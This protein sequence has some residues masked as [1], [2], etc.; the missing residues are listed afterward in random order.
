M[1][2]TPESVLQDNHIGVLA[3]VD[4]DGTPRATPL[5]FVYDGQA[6]Y[7][8]SSRDCIHSHNL[9]RQARASATV[10]SPDVGGGERGV[11]IT[12]PVK[13][14]SEAQR[15]QVEQLFTARYGA[16]PPGLRQA[17]AYRLPLGRMDE[18]QSIGRCW[19][20]YSD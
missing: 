5:H 7:W 15:P 2:S 10:F 4:D 13:M 17:Q 14:L 12:G 1:H 8:L 11:M 3:T 9:A 20:F 19:Y 6:L 18:P 16:V